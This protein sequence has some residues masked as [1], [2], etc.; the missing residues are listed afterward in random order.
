M[1][2]V[3]PTK[4]AIDTEGLMAWAIGRERAVKTRLPPDIRVRSLPEQRVKGRQAPVQI[5]AV[6]E[7]ESSD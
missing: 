3:E 7:Q 6:N 2:H 1:T 5:Y 4:R